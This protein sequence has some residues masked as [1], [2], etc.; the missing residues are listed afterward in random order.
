M[1]S[2]VATRSKRRFQF[3]EPPEIS[4]VNL[5]AVLLGVL[6][7]KLNPHFLHATFADNLFEHLF[8]I[9]PRAF[10]IVTVY[11]LLVKII[12]YRGLPFSLRRRM[13]IHLACVGFGFI[14]GDLAFYQQIDWVYV[15]SAGTVMQLAALTADT[16]SSRWLE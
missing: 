11:F 16:I 1:P 15:A 8:L 3:P 14:L 10:V 7:A 4:L 13:Q 6:L 5:A 2:T 12:I 9:A